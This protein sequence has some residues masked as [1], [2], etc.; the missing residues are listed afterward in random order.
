M[1][2]DAAFPPCVVVHGPGDALAALA[3][4]RPV[5]LLSAPGA[6]LF[7]GRGWWR[8]VVDA[9]RASR[10]ATPGGDMLDCA[11]APGFALEAIG[12]G[13]ALLVLD[14]RCAAFPALARLA[15]AGGATLLGTRPPALDLARR[16]AARRLA[17]WLG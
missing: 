4:G 8:G 10:P 7:A 2:P 1:N 6:A 17:E 11:D 15:T 12:A 14:A 5:T 16:G 13:Q 3:P 9:A